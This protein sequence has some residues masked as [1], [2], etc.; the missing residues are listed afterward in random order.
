MKS[1]NIT[2][3]FNLIN[4]FYFEKS[5]YNRQRNFLIVYNNFK[6]EIELLVSAYY[7]LAPKNKNF[8]SFLREG[9]QIEGGDL[10]TALSV[11]LNYIEQGDLI[12]L[13]DYSKSINRKIVWIIKL[14]LSGKFLNVGE[15]FIFSVLK[16]L[17]TKEELYTS[18]KIEDVELKDYKI[19]LITGIDDKINYPFNFYL[20]PKKVTYY[21]IFNFVKK[22]N[23]IKTNIKNKFI[24]NFL[25]DYFKFKNDLY[26]CFIFDKNIFVPLFL[27]N[28]GKKI[29]NFRFKKQ[30]SFDIKYPTVKEINTFYEFKALGK[31][32]V[33]KHLIIDGENIK[34]I[35][36][37]TRKTYKKII[38]YWFDENLLPVGFILENGKKI[39]YKIT[40]DIVS[41]GLEHLYV[42]ENI[43]YF[44]RQ[45]IFRQLNDLQVGIFRKCVCCGDYF[46]KF[47]KQLCPMCYKRF[48][49]VAEY[50]IDKEFIEYF[51]FIKNPYFETEVEKYKLYGIG[52]KNVKFVRDD[53]LL[54]KGYQFKLP[55]KF[56][57]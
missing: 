33:K 46:S 19:N 26:F 10:L 20:L 3:L 32:L 35:S 52:G 7:T 23:K 9:S 54:P 34:T 50:N 2:I 44:N 8:L 13:R 36:L 31:N 56:N 47:K 30:Q 55:L 41:F 27:I 29:K 53:S 11:I 1:K 40:E 45:E 39:K 48:Y 37:K 28:E 22:G 6:N 5:Y 25:K 18:L 51:D 21:K 38:D 42:Q 57:Q 16:K 17:Y 49:E 15:D 12:S 24:I 4:N 14:F 43:Y